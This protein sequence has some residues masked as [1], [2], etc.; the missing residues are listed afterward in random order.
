MM[1]DRSSDSGFDVVAKALRD[2]ITAIMQDHLGQQC[3][4]DS[5]IANAGH[6]YHL[7]DWIVVEVHDAAGARVKE[8]ER[9]ATTEAPQAAFA[10]SRQQLSERQRWVLAQLASGVKLQRRQIEEQF[11]IS[12]RTAKRK[13]AELTAAG[14]IAFDESARPGFYRIA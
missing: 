5:V 6:G 14:M 8:A 4:S 12:N 10:P 1:V 13:L 9:P 11:G 2:R 7:R 3:D